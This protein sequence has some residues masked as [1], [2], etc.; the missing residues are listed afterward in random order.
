MNAGAVECS[1]D[2]IR[3]TSTA[4]KWFCETKYVKLQWQVKKVLELEAVTKNLKFEP[5][6]PRT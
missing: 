2:G 4:A 1:E 5:V 3:E 6:A